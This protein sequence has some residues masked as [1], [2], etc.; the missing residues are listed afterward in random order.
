MLKY[1]VHEGK[2]ATT[3]PLDFYDI[4]RASLANPPILSHEMLPNERVRWSLCLWNTRI[5]HETPNP[6]TLATVHG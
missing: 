1:S 2:L 6:R 4:Q 5:P 3:T